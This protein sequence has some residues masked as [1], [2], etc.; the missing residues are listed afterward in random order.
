MKVA[1]SI[2]LTLQLVVG[3]LSPQVQSH[4]KD[5]AN[6]EINRQLVNGS[7]DKYANQSIQ[8]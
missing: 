5:L 1:L 8:T 2:L 4:I 6:K 7:D 3:Q